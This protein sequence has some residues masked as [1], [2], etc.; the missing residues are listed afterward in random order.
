MG[1]A[2]EAEERILCRLED[3]PEGGAKGFPAPPGGFVGS[4]PYARTGASGSM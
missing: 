1:Q 3:I 4:S 2:T